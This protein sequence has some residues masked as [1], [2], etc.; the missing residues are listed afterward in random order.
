MIS[1]REKAT[2][3]S[4]LEILVEV[5]AGLNT[6]HVLL[7]RPQTHRDLP[8]ECWDLKHKA[9]YLTPSHCV[10]DSGLC[11]ERKLEVAL[12]EVGVMREACDLFCGGGRV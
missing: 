12:Y 9:P 8:A 1:V 10:M 4:L 3:H 2:E 6:F 11:P 7:D 5:V